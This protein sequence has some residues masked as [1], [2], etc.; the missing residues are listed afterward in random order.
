MLLTSSFLALS[1][2]LSLFS[3]LYLYQ[4][5][6]LLPIASKNISVYGSLIKL[7]VL[8]TVRV[9]NTNIS[10][11]KLGWR[12]LSSSRGSSYLK[13]IEE[14]P[15]RLR[16]RIRIMAKKLKKENVDSGEMEVSTTE[17]EEQIIPTT[18]R[19]KRSRKSS[20]NLNTEGTGN[21]KRQTRQGRVKV[22]ESNG[23]RNDRKMI[24]QPKKEQQNVEQSDKKEVKLPSISTQ[25]RNNGN[26]VEQCITE[27]DVLPKLWQ[28]HSHTNRFK[29]LSWNVN[30]IRAVLKKYPDALPELAINHNPDLICLQ[31]TKLQESHVEDPKLKLKG[32]L[33]EKEGYDSYWSCSKTTLGYSGT[34]IFIKRKN[35]SNT[36][37]ATTITSIAKSDSGTQKQQAKLQS[38]FK[39]KKVEANTAEDSTTRSQ[40]N[41]SNHAFD[42][43]LFIPQKI[44]FGMDSN[45]DD[46]EG[47]CIVIDY[48]MF[49]II[50]TYVPNAGD[51][52]K[53]LDYRIK[54]WDVK[55][56]NEMKKLEETRGL[57]V[58][59]VGDLNV[60]MKYWFDAM[61][62]FLLL[63][64][65]MFV[66]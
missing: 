38:F 32:F 13:Q 62:Y 25:R 27:C 42:D 40:P 7:G 1:F 45:G 3:C 11:K 46:P 4:S 56:R 6:V 49:S 37:G 23:I 31:E 5:A 14:D 63:N 15:H 30:G 52:L 10:N 47:R 51:G 36:K 48:P 55:L 29:I 61:F 20:Q 64:V 33:L 28:P 50:N 58:I 35:N 43:N 12:T 39:S 24:I 17:I 57:P 22:E 60:G 66:S 21:P 41:D 34:A 54:Q 8:Q 53:R 19:G 16:E 26:K 2:Q 18:T 9:V 59:L 65:S 44:S